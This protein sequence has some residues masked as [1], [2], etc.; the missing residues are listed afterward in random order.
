MVGNVHEIL[1]SVRC[2]KREKYNPKKTIIHI[3]WQF[4]YVYGIAMI[5]LFK[6]KIQD[7][8]VQF[9]LSQKITPYPSMKQLYFYHAQRI[10]NGL[11]TGQNF[12]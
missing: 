2:K 3:V 7:A 10:H 1:R 4:S 8:E 6:G 12:S 9:F 11:K 5:L